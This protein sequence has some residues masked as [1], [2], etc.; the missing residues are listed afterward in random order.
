[1]RTQDNL[2]ILLNNTEKKNCKVVTC[3][4]QLI[5]TADKEVYLQRKTYQ[6]Y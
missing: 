5:Y 3:D 2:L 4:A 1:M 6:R